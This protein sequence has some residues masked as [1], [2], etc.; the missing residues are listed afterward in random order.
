MGIIGKYWQ[1]AVLLIIASVV[2]FYNL[3]ADSLQ[4]WDEG[5]YTLIYH[6]HS[7]PKHGLTLYLHGQPWLEKVPLGFWLNSLVVKIFGVSELAIRFLPAFFSLSAVLLVYFLGRELF[8]SRVGF[9]SALLL[10]LNPIFLYDHIS[11]RGDLEPGFLFLFLL[12]IY[13]FV[14]SWEKPEFLIWTALLAGLAF[15]YRGNS[16]LLLLAIIFGFILV[17]RGWKKYSPQQWLWSS[18]A[19]LLIVTPWHVHQLITHGREFWDIYVREHFASRIIEPMHNHSGRWYYYIFFMRWK[20]GLLASLCAFALFFSTGRLIKKIDKGYLLLSLWII[21]WLAAISLM[22]TKLFWYLVPMIPAVIILAVAFLSEIIRERKKF[23]LFLLAAV[24]GLSWFYDDKTNILAL[25]Q[26]KLAIFYAI[27]FFIAVLAAVYLHKSKR[28][29][30][31]FP[32]LLIILS[33]SLN[34]GFYLYLDYQQIVKP[35]VDPI[36]KVSRYLEQAPGDSDLDIIIYK[37]ENWMNGWVLPQAHYYLL[38]KHPRWK[39]SNS[40]EP[41]IKQYLQD[42]YEWLITNKEGLDDIKKLNVR[43]HEVKFIDRSHYLVSLL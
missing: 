1:I 9:W 5:I 18:G 10:V 37:T 21:I 35:V 29:Y 24:L 4:N 43:K 41:H 8:N 11:R 39:I 23:F 17:T 32:A 19:F 36:D 16:V 2:L 26:R 42:D 20:M 38:I 28:R 34:S 40:D 31:Y 30:Y 7:F 14:L 22:Q 33:L 25:T 3:G 13:L 6:E 12:T 15:M 27:I